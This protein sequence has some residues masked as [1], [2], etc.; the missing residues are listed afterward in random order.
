MINENIYSE[1]DNLKLNVS[2]I[3]PTIEFKG[4]VQFSH[5][6]CEHKERY[7]DF[8]KY[9][10]KN[11]YVCVIHDHRGHGDSVKDIK[12]LGNFYTE[13]ISYIV[14]DLYTVT[15]FIKEK[16]PN[17]KVTL[18][19]HSMG[20]LVARNYLKKYDNEID[21]VILCGPPTENKLAGFGIFTAKF[22]KLFYKKNKPNKLL[23]FMVF[24]SYKKKFKGKNAW[25]CSNKE[26]V[27]KY[28]KDHL[29]GFIF[30]T[31]GFINL[32]KLLQQSYN[33]KD[34]D[35]KNCDLKVLLIAGKEDPVIVNE[36][37]FN[38]L[39]YFMKRRG[40]KTVKSKLYDNMRHEILNETENKIV[41]KDIL[42]FIK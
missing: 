36:K 20:T 28:N 41:Y 4:V 3:E 39:I 6:M 34:W 14:E 9:L 11:G 7:F 38:K 2:I 12:D 30:T 8:M 29:C 17:L 1:K 42:D 5:G 22:L 32:F 35:T 25:I 19:S 31:N 18:F 40:Y 13:D 26:T 10:A 23:A 27:D 21:K 16:Y 24:R 33:Y 15:K 37:K